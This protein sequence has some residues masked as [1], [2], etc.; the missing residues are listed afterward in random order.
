V[1]EAVL[2]AGESESGISIHLVNREFDKGEVLFQA[3][4]KVEKGQ[5]VEELSK[6]IQKLEHDNFA[7]TVVKYIEKS[8]A[9]M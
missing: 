6:N 1:H 9:Q 7:D 5:T 8:D 2:A 3:K 4:C